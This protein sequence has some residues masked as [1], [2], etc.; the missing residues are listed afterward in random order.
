MALD[1]KIDGL[2]AGVECSK[3]IQRSF[4]AGTICLYTA[5][6]PGKLTVNEDTLGFYQCDDC[7]GVLV[8]ADGLG[9]LP[10]GDKA[11]AMVTREILSA[12]STGCTAGLPARE[13]IL[14]GIE[15]A[16]KEILDRYNGAA[17]TIIAM[18]ITGNAIRSYHVGDSQALVSGQKGKIKYQTIAHSPVGYAVEAGLLQEEE[19]LSHE[20]RH[21]ISNMVGSHEMRL[22]IG[23]LLTMAKRDTMVL[24][25][26]GLFDKM[27]TEEII[28]IIRCGKIEKCAEQ[29]VSICH[30]RMST[31]AEGILH[32]P[33]D[34]SF[35]LYRPG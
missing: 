22:E 25:S 12:V 28:D 34:L 8:V 16:N 1:D 23:P 11:S 26:D 32:K 5:K 29:L 20:D 21:I 10:E 4:A 33:D 17:T 30:Q 13:S 24:G 2:Y 19:A 7:T 18:E 27:T 9:G 15:R 31:Y 14:D 3:L 6:Q 35:I